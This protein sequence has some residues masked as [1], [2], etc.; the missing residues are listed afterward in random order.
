MHLN[1]N[2]CFIDRVGGRTLTVPIKTWKNTIGHFDMGGQWVG[3]SQE[4]VMDLIKE[5]HLTTFPQLVKFNYF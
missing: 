3:S 4:H 5:L 1:Y 2:N